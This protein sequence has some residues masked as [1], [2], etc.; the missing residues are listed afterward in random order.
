[1]KKVNYIRGNI[2]SKRKI[3]LKNK[4]KIAGVGILAIFII[5]VYFVFF[6][7]PDDNSERLNTINTK[8]NPISSH[9]IETV[10]FQDPKIP[11]VLCY[12]SSAKT[13]GVKGAFG[14]AEDLSD[15][16]LSCVMKGSKADITGNINSSDDLVYEESR[17]FAFKKLRVV[18]NYDADNNVVYYVAYS[19]KVLDGDSNNATSSLWLGNK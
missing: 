4:F 8:F 13:G 15:M 1:M 3:S 17:S 19:T 5:F 16:S 10:R 11:N 2:M 12:L 9:N 7:R 6:N 18:R 14:V